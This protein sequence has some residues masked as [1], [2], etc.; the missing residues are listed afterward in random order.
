MAAGRR[1]DAAAARLPPRAPTISGILRR[2]RDR[3]REKRELNI[4][5]AID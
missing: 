3:F 4:D 1:F 5:I 2:A